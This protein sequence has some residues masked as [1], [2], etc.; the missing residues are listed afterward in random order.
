MSGH[1][2]G[3]VNNKKFNSKIHVNCQSSNLIYLITCKNCS[4][5]YVG[6]TKNC[7]LTRFQGHYFDIKSQNDTTVSR[8]FNRCPPTSPAMFN[9][10]SISILSFIKSLANSNAGQNERDREEKRW[11]HRL[12]SL[13][14]NNLTG[15]SHHLPAQ[16]YHH[17]KGGKFRSQRRG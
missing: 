2:T 14:T 7:L 3:T 6:Q 9:G 10:L 8:H 15:N 5:Q 11:I 1:I 12:Q 13:W 17:Q 16:N 4:I